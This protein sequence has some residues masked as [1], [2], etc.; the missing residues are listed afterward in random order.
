[1]ASQDQV[2]EDRTAEDEE[3]LAPVYPGFLLAT[4]SQT[5][6]PYVSI[7]TEWAANGLVVPE[8][9]PGAITVGG[10]VLD[11]SG[12]PVTDA[13]IE[14]WQ[15]DS[16][17]RFPPDA[18]PPWTG[19]ARAL[20][21]TQ[22]YYRFVTVKPGPVPAPDGVMQAPHIAVSIFARGLL[23]RLVTRIYF[24]DES[25]ANAADPVLAGIGEG[26]SRLVAPLQPG[27][28]SYRFDIWLQGDQETVFFAPQ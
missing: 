28:A 8:G 17:G 26:S 12:E 5:A 20:T 16:E 21:G 25:E 18:P 13:M 10:R 3:A 14:L 24:S 1:V 15:A 2:A 11:G 9:S 19:F 7:G 27:A 4:P 22:G 23:Q 6:G